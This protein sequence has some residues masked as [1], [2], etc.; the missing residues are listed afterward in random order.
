MKRLTL[1]RS[2]LAMAT[3]SVLALSSCS[4]S[5]SAESTTSVVSPTEFND[6][7]AMFAQMMIPHHEQ[8]IE[9]AGMALDKA[10]LASS[11]IQEIANSINLTQ[12]AE[13]DLF[14]QSLVKW[15]QPYS[16]E[17]AS[18]HSSMMA[19][20]LSDEELDSL[21][22]LTATAFDEAW[23]QGMIA[24]H[25]GAIQMAQ[26]V[27]EDGANSTMRTLARVIISTQKGEIAQLQT[28][29]K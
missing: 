3:L 23:A 20:M 25:E 26:D 17:E 1:S 24:H 10:S 8:A 18:L 27:I 16:A 28:L 19:G 7:D 12:G 4:S 6:D 14:K 11:A 15:G 13:I 21:R 9:L 29:L 2:I 22:S 5:S